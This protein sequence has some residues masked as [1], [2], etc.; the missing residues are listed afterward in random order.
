MNGIYEEIRIALH[1]IWQRRWLALAVAW[2]VAILGWLVIAMIPNSYTSQARIYVQQ[3]SVLTNEIGVTGREQR[4]NI[5]RIRQTLASTAN[6][7]QVVRQTDLAQ[8]ATTDAQVRSLASQLRANVM[9]AAQ[10]DPNSFGQ[11]GN[12]FEISASWDGPG[13]ARQINQKLIDV[14]V[15]ENLAGTR[16]EATQS[17]EFLDRQIAEREQR[18]QQME[19]RRA[20]FESEYSGL[21]PGTGTIAQRMEQ[22]RSE[23]R[24]IE[25]DLAAA[26]S[27][28]STVQAQLGAT[29]AT[30]SVAGGGVAAG[31]AT[32]RLNA[33]QAQ[34]ADARARGWTDQ[35]PDVVALESQIS[36]A[37]AQARGER[38]SGRRFG[39]GVSNP[40]YTSLRSMLADRQA[41][42]AALTARRDQLR[43]GIEQIERQRTTNPGQLAELQQLDRDYLA[44]Q[45][46][47]NQ[48]V[49]DRERVRLRG[50]VVTE[51]DSNTF[52]V[53]DPP[54]MPSAPA[55]PNRPL[56]LILVLFAAIALGIAAAFAQ[57]QLKTTYPTARR[58]G[59]GTGLPVLG[60]ISEVV[61][62]ADAEIRRQNFR[63][64]A[65]GTA[66]LFGVFVVL[67]AVEFIQRGMA[68]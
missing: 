12:M 24:N 40:L 36:R 35:H 45:T 23:L 51:T 55:A 11:P 66:A 38:G 46:Q 4:A 30:T 61:K 6:L 48:L 53:V 50:D 25:G 41:Q 27:S 26:Q 57:G 58:L 31:P 2:G 3:E 10:Q 28:L 18:L 56:L 17:V 1:A 20:N 49:A 34:L 7:E 39:G 47:Y 60:A 62:P 19:E 63:R 14:F 15:E 16:A 68:A 59:S 33:L 37:R 64:F 54:S 43:A 67:M 8:Q 65:A 5:E 13:L 9:V 52:R 29:S 42:V 44:L 32:A 21:L 22:A